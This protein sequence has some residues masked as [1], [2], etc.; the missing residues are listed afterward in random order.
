MMLIIK[1]NQPW[2][3]YRSALT[4]CFKKCNRKTLTSCFQQSLC[5]NLLKMHTVLG[6]LHNKMLYK[7]NVQNSAPPAPML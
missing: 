6:Y 7:V 4:K 1:S 5:I 2:D 3:T